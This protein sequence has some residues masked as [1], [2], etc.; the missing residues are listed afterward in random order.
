MRYWDERPVYHAILPR[1]G[2]MPTEQIGRS[3]HY[4][5]SC[6]LGAEGLSVAMGERFT[7]TVSGLLFV[8]VYKH[9]CC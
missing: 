4:L 2:L 3:C 5:S 8:V 6:L 9:V 1:V 7:G